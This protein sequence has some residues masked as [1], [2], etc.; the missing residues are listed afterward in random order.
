MSEFPDA[1][2]GA[3][4]AERTSRDGHL[5]SALLTFSTHTQAPDTAALEEY[6]WLVPSHQVI[7]V[8]TRS[9]KAIPYSEEVASV[10]SPCPCL[11]Y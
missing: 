6:D 11:F 5:Q 4:L 7:S 2:P 1:G 9:F 8:L 10:T 3:H